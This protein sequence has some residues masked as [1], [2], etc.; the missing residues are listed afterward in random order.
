MGSRVPSA[1]VGLARGLRKWE[2]AAEWIES[3]N[4]GRCTKSEVKRRRVLA[5]REFGRRVGAEIALTEGI[6]CGAGDG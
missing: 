2:R 6:V 4:R 3:G 1:W 5:E